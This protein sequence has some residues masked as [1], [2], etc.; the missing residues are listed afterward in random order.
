VQGSVTLLAGATMIAELAGL[1]SID[2]EELQEA[3]LT[4]LFP[5]LRKAF[6]DDPDCLGIVLVAMQ[7][8]PSYASLRKTLLSYASYLAALPTEELLKL[9]KPHAKYVVG[10]SH[11]REKLRSGA[12][13]TRK[14]VCLFQASGL[15]S[16]SYYVNPTHEAAVA[17]ELMKDMFPEYTEANIWPSAD[18]LPGFRETFEELARLIV[19]VGARLA[20]VLSHLRGSNIRRVMH[21]VCEFEGACS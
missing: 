21:M 13:D 12:V 1:V 3:D 8:V 2:Y 5:Q 9:E 19:V 4:R 17:S 10:W 18:L 7:S 11:G 14:G 16:G 20:K 6:G 15:T